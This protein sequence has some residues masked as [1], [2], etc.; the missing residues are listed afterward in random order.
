MIKIFISLILI[1]LLI[2]FCI[3]FLFKKAKIVDKPDGVRK[4]H[5]GEISYGGGIA[6]FLSSI[7]IL[8]AS[9]KFSLSFYG[10]G[11][12]LTIIW[13]VSFIMLILGL[14]DDI[15]PLATSVRLIIQIFA[16]WLV[17]IITDVYLRDFGNLFGLGDLYIGQIGIPLTIFMVVG[18][19]NAFNMLDGID[20]LVVLVLS[21]ASL[22]ISL[23][24]FM[25][26][27]SGFIFLAS[28][29]LLSFL[30][31]NL[32][33]F[34]K[35]WKMFLG[36][37]GS[38]WLG[39]LTAWL[40]I[41]L[42]QDGIDGVFSPVTALW[43]I[44]IPLIDALSTFIS[45][46]WNRKSMFLGD[47]SHIHHMLLDLGFKK[48]KV[49]LILLVISVVS[50]IFAVTSIYLNLSEYYQFYGFLTIWFFYFLLVKYPTIKNRNIS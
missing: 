11:S 19:I 3:C 40:L 8:F 23:L 38:M 27:S 26:N 12:E 41:F 49:L 4:K 21:V 33:L 20:G 2:N 39:F 18:V 43:L 22:S 15:K 10:Q 31:F 44:L 32:G 29:S 6:L 25:E 16:S 48:W 46:I 34:G 30:P 5:K 7:V 14:W 36:D 35:N 37:S 28:F 1:S 24:L 47:R 50:A 42:S 9:S 17:I 45:R 13:L